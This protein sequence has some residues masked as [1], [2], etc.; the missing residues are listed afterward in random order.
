MGPAPS[1]VDLAKV[2]REHC[3][4]E[5]AHKDADATMLTMTPEPWVNHVPTLTGGVGREGVRAFY[6]THFI[7]CNPPDLALVPVSL[8]VGES[9][10]V[11]EMIIRFTHT[12]E[13]PW[14]LPGVA[15][16]GKK[17]EVALVAIV[18][19]EGD[20]VKSEHIYWDQASVLV[21][22]GL[23]APA[24]LP[25][26]GAESA[27]KVVDVKSEPSNVLIEAGKKKTAKA[28]PGSP[29]GSPKGTKVANF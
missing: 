1:K 4:Q 11:D 21:Q 17:V 29:K 8:T 14:L 23:L 24:G 6:A 18:G 7:P 27:R 28:G 9:S 2:W 12:C 25:V 22:V 20:K 5:F 26:A 16:T 15:P 10:V 19:F 13:V 3:A